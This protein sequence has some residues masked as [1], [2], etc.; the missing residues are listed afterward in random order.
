MKNTLSQKI[1]RLVVVASLIFGIIA[2][3]K[4]VQTTNAASQSV[5]PLTISYSGSSIFNATNIQPGD[6]IT[7][8]ISVTNNGT[9]AH[10]FSLSAENIS[11][12]LAD[13][14]QIEPRISGVAVWNL[15]LKDLAN[16]PDGSK[17]ILPSIT[18]G[19]TEN[20]ELKAILPATVNNDYQDTSTI[21][22]VF[23][24]GNEITD[25]IEPSNF[26]SS[27]SVITSPG[28]SGNELATTGGG[29]SNSLGNNQT[30]GGEQGTVTSANDVKGAAT[31][32]KASCLWWLVTLVILVLM[33]L[34]YA[35]YIR[36]ERPIFWYFWPIVMAVFMYFVHYYIHYKFDPDLI[37]TFFCDYL[38]ALEALI[39][40]A[41]YIWERYRRNR[42][43][44]AD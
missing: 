28:Q 23:R 22:F 38:W 39:L 7:K 34:S 33:L 41:F 12:K 8:N 37:R 14:L 30:S 43:I 42:E 16:L 27:S 9:L 17:I 36:D 29:T 3:A 31:T 2:F 26:Q 15:T 4:F 18:A 24:A 20:I 13:V 21:N 25:Q 5:G 32:A 6:I 35:R 19:S 40:V 11:G 10:S 44:E 1:S